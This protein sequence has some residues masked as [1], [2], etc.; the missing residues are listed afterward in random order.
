M[1]LMS[2][3]NQIP[4]EFRVLSTQPEL[5][6]RY[7]NRISHQICLSLLLLPFS[8]LFIGHSWILLSGLYEILNLRVWQGIQIFSYDTG[9]F[10]FVLT[11]VFAF[12]GL[13]V[14]FWFG[15]WSLLGVTKIHASFDSLT[16]SY[17]LLG[18][19][20]K[21]S[22]LTKDIKYLNQFLNKN[23]EGNCWDL[24]IVMNLKTSNKDWSFPAWFPAKWVSED[25]VIRMNYKTI[26]LYAHANPN[27]SEWL[28][29]VLADFYRVG[30]Q[31]T[32]QSNNPVE[33]RPY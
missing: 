26:H 12:F 32:A 9:N 1:N 25:M 10:W 28:G 31:S 16:I 20:H 29:N 24:E 17:N 18:M 11:F 8:L 6:I 13:G 23:S 19:S 21:I 2:N 30:F 4:R 5:R 14:V 15:L 3:L 22:V 7:S 33:H 27:P